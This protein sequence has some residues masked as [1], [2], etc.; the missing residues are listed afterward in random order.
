M[1]HR[2]FRVSLIVLGY[3]SFTFLFPRIKAIII[4]YHIQRKMHVWADKTDR[5]DGNFT[6]LNV[7]CVRNSTLSIWCSLSA[8]IGPMWVCR[9][10]H[11][12]SVWWPGTS[13]DCRARPPGETWRPHNGV[14]VLRNEW[15]NRPGTTTTHTNIVQQ[16][17]T[18]QNLFLITKFYQKIDCYCT[19]K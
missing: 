16:T 15:T 11:R 5:Q 4:T 8:I 6:T 13:R 12:W 9:S 19:I 7:G 1:G 2:G 14:Q 17:H 18:S 3:Y 10:R